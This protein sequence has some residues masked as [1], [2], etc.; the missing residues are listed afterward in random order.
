MINVA[1]VRREIDRGSIVDAANLAL[2][3]QGQAGTIRDEATATKVVG[4]LVQA[5]LNQKK[6]EIA[7]FL[8]WGARCDPRPIFVREVFDFWKKTRRGLIL[9][10]GSTGKT[11]TTAAEFYLDWYRDPMWTATKI[12]SQTKEHAKRNIFATI[13]ALHE[14][15]AVKVAAT[16]VDGTLSCNHDDERHGIQQVAIAEGKS[17]EGILKGFHPIP[18]DGDPHPVFGRYSRVRVL[19]DEGEHVAV[20]VWHGVDNMILAMGEDEQNVKIGCVTNPEDVNSEFAYRAT[21]PG[22]WG[23]LNWDTDRRWKSETGWDVMRVDGLRSENVISGRDLYPGFITRKGVDNLRRGR[24]IT[25]AAWAIL[26]RGAYPKTG[27]AWTVIT[28]NLFDQMLGNFR[29]QQKTVGIWSF[30]P[31]LNG[32]DNAVLTIGV[33][34]WATHWVGMQP[35]IDE[36]GVKRAREVETKFGAPARCA[37]IEQQIIVPKG[38]S[39]DVGKRAV[40]ILKGFNMTPE[41]GAVD[42][43]GSSEGVATYMKKN[44]GPVLTVIAGSSAS[45]EPI[46]EEFRPKP[47]QPGKPDPKMLS[48]EQGWL[49]SD[50]YVDRSTEVAFA[51]Q[52]WGQYHVLKIAPGAVSQRLAAEAV[53][54]KFHMHGPGKVKLN[55]KEEDAVGGRSPDFFDSLCMFTEPARRAAHEFPITGDPAGTDKKRQAAQE[56]RDR[57][58][59]MKNPDNIPHFEWGA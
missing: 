48:A 24:G 42:G 16:V 18:R 34:G 57:I 53:A 7:A 31:A 23:P 17:G 38:D 39:E 26:V 58:D 37:L 19:I 9:G 36:E 41:N 59:D 30:D 21:P 51:T 12:V 20:G 40:E 47:K 45:D 25:S 43:T 49:A 13:V 6:N 52:F 46:L 22:G 1:L 2:R 15:A 5:L 3:D 11:Y 32:D 4:L 50:R 55:R 8:M 10:A 33:T 56:S 28:Q 29:W 27:A 44:W 54:R 35:Y 14:S